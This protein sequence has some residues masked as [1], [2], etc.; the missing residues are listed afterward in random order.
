MEPTG[1]RDKMKIACNLGLKARAG[2]VL[3]GAVLVSLAMIVKPV[4]F[5]AAVAVGLVGA[6]VAIEGMVGF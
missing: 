1:R 5:L 3:F 2:Y 4:Y 6:I